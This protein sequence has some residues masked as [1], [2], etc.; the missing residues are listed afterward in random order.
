MGKLNFR[1]YL[2]SQFYPTREIRENLVHAKNVLQYITCNKTL[3][4]AYY[5]RRRVRLLR[6]VC[7]QST[8][9][10]SVHFCDLLLCYYLCSASRTDIVTVGVRRAVCLSAEMRLHA[11]RISLCSE[12]NAL[13]PVLSGFCLWL[14]EV[15]VEQS[16]TPHPTQ[17]RSFRRQSSQP[18]TWLILTNKAV[19]GNKHT[20]TKYKHSTGK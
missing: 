8:A 17:Y 6:C 7:V 11:H 14:L 12:G 1:G 2:I 9:L 16:L 10:V 4:T 5:L 20:V 19:Q 13:Y 18:I 15:E 3:F